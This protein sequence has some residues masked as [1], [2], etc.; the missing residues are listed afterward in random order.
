[1]FMGQ[2][3]GI[4][5]KQQTAGF[6]SRLA[7]DRSGNTLMI[8]AVSLVPILAMIGGGID[9]G[10]GYLS[11]SRLQQACDSG[12]L[13]ARKKLGGTAA[14]TG[15]VPAGVKTAGDQFFDMNFQSGA[16]GTTLR[17]FQMT[18]DADYSISGV[19][20]VTVPTTLMNIFGY[21]SLPITVA[22]QAKIN[23]ANTDV[24]MVLDT[25]G[26]MNQTNSG[27]P[28]SKIGVLRDTVKAFHTQL[29]AAKTPGTRIRYGFVPYA[30]NVNVGGL[31]KSSWLVDDWTYS[32]REAHNTGTTTTADVWDQRWEYVSGAFAYGTA[33]YDTT[34]PPY[35]VTS[36]LLAQGTYP[37]GYEWWT[38]RYNGTGANCQTEADGRMQITPYTYTNYTE[39]Y[40]QKNMGPR[41]TANWDWK[42][43]PVSL[44]VATF[45][46]PNPDNPP[47]GGKIVTQMGGSPQPG[48]HYME[49][50]YNGCIEER[51]TYEITDYAN[52]DLTRALDLDLDLVPTAGV[53]ATQWRPQLPDVAWARGITWSNWPTWPWV[54][55]ESFYDGDYIHSGWNGYAACPSPAQ[56]LAEMNATNIAA[57][58]DGLIV[59]GNTYHDIGMIWGG[60]LLSPTGLFTADN[61]DISGKPTQRHLIFLTDGQTAPN[62]LSYSSYGIEG[63][64]RRRWAPGSALTLTQ[65]IE[66]RFTVACNEVKKKNITV[67]V[68]SFGTSLNPMLSECAGPG[69]AF[70]AS[71][72]AQL[73][74]TFSN[75]A[76]SMGDLRISK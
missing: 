44:G 9:M 32:G 23:F 74:T 22:C 73:S 30:V 16:Y 66:K 42:Y 41:T 37:T 53:P 35:S 3:P 47:V 7:H 10:R 69:H 25:T 38:R 21:T 75:I 59:R 36:E 1:M 12:V 18:V 2:W 19:A 71:S 70:E 60:R 13:A 33:Y 14:A 46:A 29:E 28:K 45:K 31:L 34:C 52:V 8:V 40:S 68:I 55:G 61:A 57:Y 39:T 4:F 62:E 48:N 11:E 51:D 43:M 50:L 17:D 63:L 58:V 6:L 56:K 20:K 26:S 64:D 65:V 76:E 67:W 72:A 5:V 27:D 24:M 49:A 15:V 54:T